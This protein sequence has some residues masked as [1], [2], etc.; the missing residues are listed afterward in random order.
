MH[1]RTANRSRC[2]QLFFEL[3]VLKN[4]EVCNFIKRRL[5]NRCFPV[6]IA[7]FF[8]TVFY[9]TPPAAAFQFLGAQSRVHET[10]VQRELIYYKESSFRM[11]SI[12]IIFPCVI[13]MQSKYRYTFF[14]KQPV[15]KQIPRMVDC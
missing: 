7:K 12:Q 5:H 8:R 13:S 2:S 11:Y 4:F 1:I 9:R 6:N 3:G 15:Y 14:Y 10:G